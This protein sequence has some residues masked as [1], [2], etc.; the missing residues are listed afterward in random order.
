LRTVGHLATVN[1][2]RVN[3]IRNWRYG[4]CN[5]SAPALWNRPKLVDSV[6]GTC[7]APFHRRARSMA[8]G[9]LLPSCTSP[10][11]HPSPIPPPRRRFRSIPNGRL[12][13]GWLPHTPECSPPLGCSRLFMY[14]LT[15]SMARST[16]I[17]RSYI[18]PTSAKQV[19][20]TCAQ[21]GRSTVARALLGSAGN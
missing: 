17:C 6:S 14:L 9:H 16:A 11:M 18:A 15:K 7:G 8:A 10:P 12:V 4:F 21:C 19:F 2:L 3:Y 5:F 13:E 1:S 20:P